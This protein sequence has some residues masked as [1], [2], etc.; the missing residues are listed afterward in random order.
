MKSSR[1]F[2][3]AQINS[4]VIPLLTRIAMLIAVS[5]LAGAE[6][7]W[8][9]AADDAPGAMPAAVRRPPSLSDVNPLVEDEVVTSARQAALAGNDGELDR[10]LLSQMSV[11]A[12]AVPSVSLARRAVGVCAWLR[13]DGS[14]GTA[15]RV[16][17]RVLAQL[18]SM[19]ESDDADR[20]ERLYWEAMLRVDILDQKA[21]ALERLK[22]AEA[23]APEDER[24]LA[25]AQQLAQALAE[26][27]H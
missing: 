13:S 2:A 18:A 9:Q 16:A 19:R 22:E 24:L 4:G 5:T 12:Q 3:S 10:L 15:I 27:G 11:H 20:V 14:H 8:A 26:F 17:E 25:C 1:L 23:L 6:T 7:A 21:L